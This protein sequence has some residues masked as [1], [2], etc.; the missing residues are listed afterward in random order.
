MD[1]IETQYEVMSKATRMKMSMKMKAKGKMIARKRA[2]SM[3]KRASPEKILKRATKQARDLLAKKI[4]KDRSKA[5][6]SIS[7]KEA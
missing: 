1:N 4:L 3:K 7:G 5:D 2:I 6:L